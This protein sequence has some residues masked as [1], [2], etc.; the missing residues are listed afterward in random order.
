[1]HF[2]L[3]MYPLKTNLKTWKYLQVPAKSLAICTPFKTVGLLL[4][5]EMI[6][7]PICGS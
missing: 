3:K 5:A 7:F 2:I 4:I 6:K 1:M